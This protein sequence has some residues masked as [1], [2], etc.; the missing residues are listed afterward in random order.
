MQNSSC[1]LLE[2]VSPVSY[3]MPTSDKQQFM[4][5]GL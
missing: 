2:V 3:S 4:L 5:F 1:N